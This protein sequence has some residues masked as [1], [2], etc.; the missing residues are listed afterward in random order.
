MDWFLGCLDRAVGQAVGLTAGVLREVA[1]W[2]AVYLGTP[3]LRG[4]EV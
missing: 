4:P 2:Q 1:V 3:A